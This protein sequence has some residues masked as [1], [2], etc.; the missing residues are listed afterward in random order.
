MRIKCR[1]CDLN[2]VEKSLKRH[3]RTMHNI[4]FND[5]VNEH[6]NDFKHWKKCPICDIPT[7]Q[8]MT[9]SRK[10]EA[11]RKSIVYTGRKGHTFTNKQKQNISKA[12][13]LQ[14]NPWNVGKPLS[15][16]HRA[17]ISK[18]RIK[19]KLAIGKN[20]GMY[21]KTH[22][23]EAIKKIFSYRKM[24]TVEKLVADFLDKNN[25]DYHFQF[26]I[27][28]NSICKSYDFKIKD[29]PLIIEV[30]GDFWHGGPGVK[31]YWKDVEK[32]K[33]ND[34]LKE[35]LANSKGY[36]VIRFWQSELKKDI[37]IISQY[38]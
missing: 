20:N 4:N 9:C 10:C 30:D 29:K 17:A 36:K 5:Y 27:N 31:K 35:Q 1:I 13:K 19:K 25:I 34:L 8:K 26:F 2:S 14:G 22:S 12:R 3:I 23:P 32:V 24:N 16:E 15:K 6:L 33:E 28:E 11:D 18:T 21:G 37:N 38:L 7:L